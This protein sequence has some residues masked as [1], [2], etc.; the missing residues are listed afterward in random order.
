MQAVQAGFDVLAGDLAE[1]VVAHGPLHQRG[2]CFPEVA[3]DGCDAA[4]TAAGASVFEGA[5]PA[6][7]VAADRAGQAVEL[8]VQP[9]AG[10][11]APV[12]AQHARLLEDLGDMPGADVPGPQRRQRL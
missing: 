5:Q 3:A 4:G 11:R 7:D 9:G 8:T 6:L 1:V 10:G 2:E 12:I